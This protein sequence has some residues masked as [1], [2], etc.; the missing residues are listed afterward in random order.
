[1]NFKLVN[2]LRAAGFPQ[3]RSGYFVDDAGFR[4]YQPLDVALKEDVVYIPTLEEL[5]KEC[6]EDFESLRRVVAGFKAQGSTE[7]DDLE[8][9]IE[10]MEEFGPT[11]LE[12]VANLWLSIN[13]APIR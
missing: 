13:K 8:F 12:A 9:P 7:V 1:M 5:I 11:P 4:L 6:G 3:G 2:E 10:T